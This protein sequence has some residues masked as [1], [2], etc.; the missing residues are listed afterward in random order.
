[1]PPA[2]RILEPLIPTAPGE[3]APGRKEEGYY[4]YTVWEEGKPETA[5]K[6]GR[7]NG[8]AAAE[9]YVHTVLKPDKAVIVVV[10]GYGNHKRYS[11]E[12]F[13]TIA[14]VINELVE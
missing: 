3:E 13:Q 7:P 6:V 12:P 10:K 9:A 4:I 2:E 14:Y 5:T 1:M 11:I 8:F